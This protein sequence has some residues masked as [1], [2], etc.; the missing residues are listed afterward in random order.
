MNLKNIYLDYNATTPLDPAVLEAMLPWLR[1]DF[2]NPS[3]QHSS[4]QRAAAAVDLA[5]L[6]V[7]RLIDANPDEIIFTG[8]AT[9][10]NNTVIRNA[11]G[12]IVAGGTEHSSI[13]EPARDAGAVFLPVTAG[14]QLIPAT[15]GEA[16]R[17]HSPALVSLILANNETGVITN[18]EGVAEAVHAAGAL[19]HLDAVQAAGKIPLSVKALKAD[20]LSLSAHKFYGP[21]GVGAL[22]VR[23]GI[24]LAPLLSGGGQ[25]MNR[26]SGTHNVPAIVGMGVACRLAAARM[27]ED[28][29]HALILRQRLE[30]NILD[31]VPRCSVNGA[32]EARLPNTLNI[33]FAGIDAGALAARLNLEGIEV[34]VGS[35]CSSGRS[36]GSRILEAMGLSTLDAMSAIRFSLGRGIDAAMIDHTVERLAEMVEVLRA[37]ARTANVLDLETD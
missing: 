1:E 34:S 28:P 6:Q 11:G 36:S 8:G 37:A 33:R 21:K 9:E 22:F 32:V 18:L 12:M 35:A 17:K 7:A 29:A 4:G 14:G 30:T 2:G 19:L 23:R 5:R 13:Y 15:L 24:R 16:L 31:A 27:D 10:A 3:S 20:F 26:R 25:E